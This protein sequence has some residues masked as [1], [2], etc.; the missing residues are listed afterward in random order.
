MSSA[1]QGH[2]SHLQPDV[3][4]IDKSLQ[5][6]FACKA[7]SPAHTSA[8]I[9]LPEWYHDFSCQKH[10]RRLI[11]VH[12]VSKLTST[13]DDFDVPPIGLAAGERIPYSYNVWY[14][15]PDSCMSFNSHLTS[16]SSLLMTFSADIHG[17]PAT[18]LIDSGATHG[19]I[20]ASLCH[21]LKLHIH[22]SPQVIQCGGNASV[23]SPGHVNVF[24]QLGSYSETLRLIVLPLS[25]ST[26]FH[27]VL[28]QLWL[29]Q[30]RACVD[31][32]SKSVSFMHEHRLH[33]L[34]SGTSD[35]RDCLL[36][37]AEFCKQSSEEGAMSYTMFASLATDLDDSADASSG[38][39]SPQGVC[40]RLR[41]NSS[42][43]A[44]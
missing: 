18:V 32:S 38:T 5:H 31:Y 23:S 17:Q 43:A 19:F 25:P 40:R 41:S 28:G 9:A 12:H 36:S 4:S 26:S 39:I 6:Y 7:A 22:Q 11:L 2:H 1:L 21:Q 8:L 42:R 10:T 24:L 16:P 35:V 44:S 37:A 20:S 13:T 30:H 29:L 27:L 33:S 34:H 15:P 3:K 14:E